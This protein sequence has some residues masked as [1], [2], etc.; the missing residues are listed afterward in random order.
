MRRMDMSFAPTAAELQALKNLPHLNVDEDKDLT[1][2]YEAKAMQGGFPAVIL[3]GVLDD[4][5]VVL[6]RMSAKMFLTAAAGVQGRARFEG[7][8]TDYAPIRPDDMKGA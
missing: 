1:L 3:R 6:L 2:I 4:G 7:V 5:Q 8:M